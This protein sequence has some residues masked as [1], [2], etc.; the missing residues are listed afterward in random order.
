MH[1]LNFLFN[2]KYWQSIEFRCTTNFLRSQAEEW[3]QGVLVDA[4]QKNLV[5]TID[6]I[7]RPIPE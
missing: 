6:W 2:R 7:N 3:L 5:T 1:F 4:F